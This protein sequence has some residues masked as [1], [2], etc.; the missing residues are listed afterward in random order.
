MLRRADLGWV[1]GAFVVSVLGVLLS[2]EKWNGLLRDNRIWLRFSTAALALLGRHVL[3]Q[4]SADQRR[5]RRDALVMTPSR[6][7][8]ERVAGTIVIERLTG[9]LVMLV[10]S[11]VGLLFGPLPRSNRPRSS[12]CSQLLAALLG[13]VAAVLLAPRLF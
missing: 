1:A 2:A 10:F 9:F 11:A 5:R 6:G 13:A 7:R 3:Q 4:F 12:S 8:T